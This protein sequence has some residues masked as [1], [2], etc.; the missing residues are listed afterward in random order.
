METPRSTIL[1]LQAASE[2]ARAEIRNVITGAWVNG[3]LS[4]MADPNTY[5]ALGTLLGQMLGDDTET[6]A[7]TDSEPGADTIGAKL[8]IM[9]LNRK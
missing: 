7:E 8:W 6:E 4:G 3:Q 2:R 1:A 9:F 5:P